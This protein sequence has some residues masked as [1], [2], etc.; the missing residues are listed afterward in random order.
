MGEFFTD[1]HDWQQ[2][3]TRSSLVEIK[4]LKAPVPPS[5]SRVNCYVPA[6]FSGDLEL[7]ETL[8]KSQCTV[9]LVI[10]GLGQQALSAIRASF[11]EYELVLVFESSHITEKSFIEQ[12]TWLNTQAEPFAV[13]SEHEKQWALAAALGAHSLIISSPQ[14]MDIDEILYLDALRQNNVPRPVSQEEV[15]HLIGKE[16]SLTVAQELQKGDVLQKQDLLMELTPVTGLAPS[17]SSSVIGRALRYS[18]KPGEALTFGH[19]EGSFHAG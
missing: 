13:R 10:N 19:L 11:T 15:D 18:I 16:V 17:L 12:V 4:D 6:G 3:Q 8:K 7:L 5:S 9:F 14:K 1:V 2:N